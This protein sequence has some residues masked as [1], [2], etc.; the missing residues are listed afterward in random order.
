MHDSQINE[1]PKF[2]AE[3]QDLGVDAFIIGD[4]GAISIAKEYAPNVAIH[5]S[6]QASVANTY[7]AIQYAKLGVK[8]IV[9]AREMSLDEIAELRKNLD[10]KGYDDLELEAF[11]HGAMCMSISG[12][13]L[14]SSYLTGRSANQGA[15]TQPCR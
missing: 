11:V 5:V 1:L 14:I 2:F 8:R 10:S 15:C 12:R 4:V 3:M 7:A 6:T 13:C 9:L